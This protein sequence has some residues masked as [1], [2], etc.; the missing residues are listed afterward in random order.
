VAVG[1]G[2]GAINDGVNASVEVGVIVGVA[3]G[4]VGFSLSLWVGRK[5]REVA[6]VSESGGKG[7]LRRSSGGRSGTSAANSFPMVSV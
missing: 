6:S 4:M 2:V 1:V 7:A 5:L 3:A